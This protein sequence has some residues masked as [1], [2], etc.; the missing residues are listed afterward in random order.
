MLI[1][2]HYIESIY[3]ETLSRNTD[4]Y[5]DGK[6]LERMEYVVSLCHDM[7]DRKIRWEGFAKT[8]R[9]W[10]K[11]IVLRVIFQSIYYSSVCDYFRFKNHKQME[12]IRNFL[13][14]L[15]NATYFTFHRVS[16]IGTDVVPPSRYMEFL[17]KIRFNFKYVSSN[18]NMELFNISTLDMTITELGICYAY[19]SYVA[20]Y[21]SFE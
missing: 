16:E 1:R 15:S 11:K 9:Y 7:S 12:E 21:N 17:Y 14:N 18:S 20:R 19:N 5:I 6:E 3:L 13:I 2:S 4:G 8:F 10:V